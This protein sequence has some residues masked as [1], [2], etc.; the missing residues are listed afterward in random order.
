MLRYLSKAIIGL[1]AIVVAVSLIAGCGSTPTPQSPPETQVPPD[2]K[3][4]TFH[5]QIDERKELAVKG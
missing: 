3:N 4:A 5:N 1:L 2:Q